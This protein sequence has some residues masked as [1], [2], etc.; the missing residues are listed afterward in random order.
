[1]ASKFLNVVSVY[2]I[3][4][5][6]DFLLF[7]VAVSNLCLLYEQYLPSAI[8]EDRGIFHCFYSGVDSLRKNI[9]YLWV[10]YVPFEF[11]E[12]QICNHFST[13]PPL[14]CS[15]LIVFSKTILD[16]FFEKHTHSIWFSINAA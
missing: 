12:V 9:H 6:A 10:H 14:I 7:C 2:F 5:K 16:V 15:L 11:Y 4:V 3:V 8:K 1:M 13:V